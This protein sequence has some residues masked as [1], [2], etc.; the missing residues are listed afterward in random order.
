MCPR[1]AFRDAGI[2]LPLAGAFPSLTPPMLPRANPSV[3]FQ[4][5]DDGAVLFAPE[6]E[7]YFGLNEVGVAVWEL[8][9]PMT[10]SLEQLCAMIASRYPE[11]TLETIRD[12]VEEVLQQLVNEGLARHADP[13]GTDVAA[14]S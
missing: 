13:R 9:P 3:I 4:K 2:L 6:T 10:D 1:C 14:A 7:L 12:D 11:V 5:L 8:L